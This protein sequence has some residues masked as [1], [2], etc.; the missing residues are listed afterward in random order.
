MAHWA[1]RGVSLAVGDVRGSG[2]PCKKPSGGRDSIARY[3]MYM[4]SDETPL[5][6]AR[7]GASAEKRAVVLGERNIHTERV[8]H[9]LYTLR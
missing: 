4:D 2:R 1:S 5:E 7:T 3:G 9:V 8:R 6:F